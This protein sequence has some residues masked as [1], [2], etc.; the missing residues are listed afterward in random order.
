M[1]SKELDAVKD[2]IGYM[3]QRFGLYSD[4]T[5]DENMIFYSD[6]FGITGQEREEL[7]TRLL[8]MTRMEP[9]R[10]RAGGKAVGRDET[11]AGVDVHAAAQAPRAVSG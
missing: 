11:E 3:A 5:V 7:T 1:W 2:Q 6:L 8:R 9:F 4:L 10:K